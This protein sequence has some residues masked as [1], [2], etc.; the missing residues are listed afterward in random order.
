MACFH[1]LIGSQPPSGGRPKFSGAQPG[2]SFLRIPCGQCIGCRT[3]RARAWSVRCL[4]EAQTV[5]TERSWFVTCTYA[6]EFNPVSLD[7]RDHTLFLKRVRNRFGPVRF[8]MCGEY[9]EHPEPGAKF[10]RPHFHYLL[11]GLDLPDLKHHGGKGSSTL[12]TS[13]ALTEAW[14]KGHV[15]LGT[16]TQESAQYVA[17]YINKKK[18]GPKSSREAFYRATDPATGRKLVFHPE[19]S[20]MSLKPGIGA[21]WFA[22]FHGDVFPQDKFPLKGGAFVRP[23]KYFDTL[24]ERLEAKGAVVVPLADIKEKR[25][26]RALV[27]GENLTDARL[28]V[29]AECAESRAKF[30]KKKSI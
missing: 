20:R 2:D 26:A 22:R 21:E 12:Y 10:G 8:Y 29:R 17:G 19:F 15:V 6:P 5:G 24:Y 14:G 16:V 30:F 23:P 7:P 25:K 1:P 9:G 11:F 13:A 27:E 3:D 18:L 4:G 28:R